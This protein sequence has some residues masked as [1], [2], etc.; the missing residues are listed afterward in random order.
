MM[1]EEDLVLRFERFERTIA[2]CLC[3]VPILFS[4]QCLLAAI[5]APVFANMFKDFGA[6]LPWLTQFVIGTW[7]FW[8][9]VAVAVPIAALIIARKGRATFSVV[10]S[11]VTGVAIFFVAQFVTVA[12]FLPI[13]E[14]G[15]V[16]GGV[17]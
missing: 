17:K 14:L 4:A 6:K 15:T 12:L 10:F 1:K 9:L 13:F 11:T 16:A 5:S 3:T 2:T 7:Q 8:A